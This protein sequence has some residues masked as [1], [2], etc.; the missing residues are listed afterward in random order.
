MFSINTK[1]ETGKWFE[2][3]ELGIKLKVRPRSMYSL[4]IRPGED[5]SPTT[6][7][8]FDLFNYSL[9]DWEGVG[10]EDGKKLAC[11]TDTKY[12]MINQNDEVGAFV[13]NKA[14]ELRDGDVTEQEAKNLKK[15]PSGET[16]KS[17]KPPAPTV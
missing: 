15:S 9:I 3:P 11:N 16:P 8:I 12:A 5:Y 14:S 10:D 1:L 17:E 7:D 13:I 4:S 2:Y 6:K